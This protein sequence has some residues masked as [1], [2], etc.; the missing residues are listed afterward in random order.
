MKA[1]IIGDKGQLGYE[2][3]RSA[4]SGVEIVAC[5]LPEVNITD[6]VQVR[7]VV[8]ESGPD[9]IMNSAAYTAVDR[10]EDERDVAFAVNATAVG[11]IIDAARTRG[12]RLIHVSTDFIFDGRKGSPYQPGDPS[13]PIGVYGE[14][15]A[16]GE[17]VVLQNYPDRSFI[18]RTAW[19]Y[20]A[21]GANFV[22]TMLRL[23]EDRDVLGVV[24]DQVGTPTWARHLACFLWRI[25]LSSETP[26]G[27]YHYT[28]A[29]VAS[30]YDFTVAI[31]EETRSR[32]KGKAV[33]IDP[34]RTD[35]Y[36]TKAR[37][38][39]YSVLEKRFPDT[40]GEFP[41]VHWREALRRMLAE[42]FSG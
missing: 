10:A 28:D 40:L 39:S 27:I 21:H 2:L 15:K 42:L 25:A 32:R 4:P 22:K 33:R 35:E 3:K 6:P 38:P 20:S 41:Y 24:A 30:W 19:L 29:G 16:A 7:K 14:S 17:Q 9:V 8:D 37:R 18:V 12:S 26:A 31:E 5:D 23:F 1:L 36:P 11:Y 34:I 13:S